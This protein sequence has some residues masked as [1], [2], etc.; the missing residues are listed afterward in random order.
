MTVESVASKGAKGQDEVIAWLLNSD[1]AIRWQ[2]L[3]DLIG[4]PEAAVEAERSRV[5]LQG[6]GAALLSLQGSDGAWS[7]ALDHPPWHSTLYTL[8]LLSHFGLDPVSE[9]ARRA[10]ELLCEKFTWGMEFDNASFFDG[11]TEPCINGGVL[12]LGGYFGKPS[13]RLVDRLLGEQLADGGWNCDA[14]KSRR[15]SFHTTICVLEGLLA[16]EKTRGAV[17]RVSEARIRGQEYLLERQLFQRR[18]TG[19]VV[20]PIWLQ[21]SFPA[22]WHY[23]ILRGLD[24][25]RLAGVKADERVAQAVELV[26]RSCQPDGRWL[27]ADPR[28]VAPHWWGRPIHFDLGEP[29]GVASRWNTLRALRV[30]N[31]FAA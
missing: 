17:S 22:T 30:L 24:Y 18:S 1:P 21:F 14:P 9:P 10:V 29:D 15:S 6:W 25:L 5:P 31:W 19:E 20:N 11:E 8:L 7:D 26:A 4:E 2:V 23:D 3:R 27:Q 12:A 16:Y 13:D 28:P